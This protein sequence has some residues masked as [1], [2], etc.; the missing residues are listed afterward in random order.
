VLT[1]HHAED[2]EFGKRGLAAAE[3]L[4]D[5]LV[6]VWR[7]AVLADSLQRESG[8]RRGWHGRQFYCRISTRENDS[9]LNVVLLALSP[10]TILLK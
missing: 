9:A 7:E 8:G 2:A 10:A 5:L 1:P 6:F 3:K 4:L